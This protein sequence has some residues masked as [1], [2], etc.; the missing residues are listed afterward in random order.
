MS[1]KLS[2]QV[3]AALTRKKRALEKARAAKLRSD[4]ARYAALVRW[5]KIVP[6]Q[7]KV[8]KKKKTGA[9][10]AGAPRAKEIL[11]DLKP[12]KKKKPG[13]KKL[14]PVQRLERELEKEKRERRKEKKKMEEKLQRAREKGRIQFHGFVKMQSR[15]TD[16]SNLPERMKHETDRHYARRLVNLVRV[17]NHIMADQAYGPIAQAAHL[18]Y[19][20]VYTLFMSPQVA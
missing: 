5:G 1:K 8:P 14:T 9:P 7:P 13:P 11:R 3:K 2:P 16:I 20:E 15:F 18:S 12:K 17:E 19:R 10:R 6:I 4:R